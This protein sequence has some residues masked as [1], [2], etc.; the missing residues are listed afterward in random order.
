MPNRAPEACPTCG[1]EPTL[2]K[3]CKVCGEGEWV[4]QHLPSHQ[5][6]SGAREV[7]EC[8][9]SREGTKESKAARHRM[10]LRQEGKVVAGE[11]RRNR[12]VTTP[13]MAEKAAEGL[14]RGL[15]A[16]RALEEAGF[17]PST[18]KNSTRG[19]NKTIWA[20][21]KEKRQY[22][23]ALGEITAEEQEKL[24]RGRLVWNTIVGTDKGTLSAKQLGA[25]KRISMWQPDS[26]AGMVVLQCPPFPKIDHH[27]PWLP[28]QCPMCG[29]EL[30]K[31]SCID[32]GFSEDD[33][34]L[35]AGDE[36]KDNGK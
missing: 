35:P 8:L 4:I 31:G 21:F 1:A 32:C 6:W 26:H 36:S 25:D 14:A 13:E 2:R 12:P 20:K 15:S 3:Q 28:P 19:I 22:Y 16:R 30:I 5:R 29:G 11:S 9:C 18:V 10:K 23:I 34:S 33:S 24:S 17:P 27:V 7:V